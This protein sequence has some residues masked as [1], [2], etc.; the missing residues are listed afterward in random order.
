MKGEI[1]MVFLFLGSV[2]ACIMWFLIAQGRALRKRIEH[3]A[4]LMI[5]VI[6]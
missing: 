4:L 1:I 2:V 3:N 6:K 5:A